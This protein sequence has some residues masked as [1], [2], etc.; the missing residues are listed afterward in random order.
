VKVIIIIPTLNEENSIKKLVY[1][2]K[3]YLKQ[4]SV[5]IVDDD[6][7]DTTQS[8]IIKFKKKFKRINFIFKK[9]NFG[10]GSAIKDGI[11]YAIQKKYDAC[12]TMDADGTHDPKKITKM[13]K[14][15]KTKKYDIV[16]TNRFYYK[17]SLKKWSFY[18]IFLTKLRYYIVRILLNTNLD[19]SG[20]FRAYNL[21]KIKSKHF[22][23]SKNK[24]Y[25]YLIESLFYLEKLNYKIVEIPIILHPRTFDTSKMRLKHIL[26]SLISLLKLRF[27]K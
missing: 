24:S 12:I 16:S 2:L 9:K 11:K 25:F 23:L 8:Q 15:I 14:I 26:A 4:Y 27:F 10:I 13:I 19:S 1:S 21:K 3:E 6:S 18:R 17:E 20:N 7:S 5:L 22:F